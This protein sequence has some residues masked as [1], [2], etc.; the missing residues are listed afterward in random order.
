MASSQDHQAEDTSS[1]LGDSTY[2]ILSESTFFTS[3]DE[4]HEDNTDWVASNDRYTGDD[5]ASLAD[6]DDLEQTEDTESAGSPDMA[7]TVDALGDDE[8]T[9]RGDVEDSS[10]ITAKDHDNLS[11]QSIEFEEPL[12]RRDVEEVDVIHTVRKFGSEEAFEIGRKAYPREDSVQLV[13]TVRQTMTKQGLILDRPFRIVFVGDSSYQN[14]IVEKIG[15]ALAVPVSSGHASHISHSRSSR[16]SVV[17]ISSFGDCVSPEVELIDSSGLE[18]IVDNCTSAKAT[19]GKAG[20]HTITLVLNESLRCHSTRD[21]FGSKLDVSTPWRLPDIAV[22]FWPVLDSVTAHQT[23]QFALMF[24]SRHKVPLIVISQQPLWRSSTEPMTLDYKSPHLCLESRGGNTSDSRVLRRLPIDLASFKNIDA[25]QMNRNLACLTGLHT[26]ADYF[27]VSTRESLPSN[28]NGVY[29]LGDLEKAP[30]KGSR[31]TKSLNRLNG[32]NRTN[33]RTMLLVGALLLCTV[34]YTL[35]PMGHGR[36]AQ[37]NTLLPKAPISANTPMTPATTTMVSSPGDLSTKS[38][39]KASSVLAS[40]QSNTD[41]V[42]KTVSIGDT[43]MDL[44]S[45][46]LDPSITALNGSDQC[47]VQVI[48]D[49]HLILRPPHSVTLSKKKPK[50]WV[51]V[52]R[53]DHVLEH[54]LSK[55]FEGVYVVELHRADTYGS[56]NVSVW[57]KSKPPFNQTFVIDFGTPWLKTQGWKMAAD[58]MLMQ[59][60]EKYETRLFALEVMFR[61]ISGGIRDL[62]KRVIPRAVVFQ[63]VAVRTDKAS[64]QRASASKDTFISRFLALSSFLSQR[65]TVCSEEVVKSS[66]KVSAKTLSLSKRIG[67]DVIIRARDISTLG[68]RC[69]V[70]LCQAAT[71][72]DPARLWVEIAHLQGVQPKQPLR[73]AQKSIVRMWKRMS[74]TTAK[75]AASPHPT[76]EKKSKLSIPRNR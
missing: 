41:S 55:L 27:R 49:C 67:E 62:K 22:I 5:L 61:R 10:T 39:N 46:L 21:D 69:L 32:V 6:T 3:E 53:Q 4:D 38:S 48:G 15:A 17:P 76:K 7:R 33:I 66:V 75:N 68:T 70:T 31:L 20:H 11:L 59:L 74:R 26:R 54:E 37:S 30:L 9:T 52:S 65:T 60:K 51:E 29:P 73:V 14:E 40:V 57:I 44:T 13:A 1:S 42:S 47:K 50:L 18:I 12:S 63:D 45:L 8:Q 58:V 71:G 23:R 64:L 72:V 24:M 2:E 28:L 36:S 19:E 25:G 56:L 16:F 34:A 35:A 43:N